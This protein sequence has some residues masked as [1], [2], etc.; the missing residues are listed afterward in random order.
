MIVWR[1]CIIAFCRMAFFIAVLVGLSCT[2]AMAA[3][4]AAGSRAYNQGDYQGALTHWRPL[5]DQGDRRA[6]YNLGV[7]YE[8][9]HGVTQDSAQAT[10]LWKQAATSGLVWAQ[11]NLGLAL[12]SLDSENPE[13]DAGV[14]WL[15]RASDQGFAQS[16]YALAE[17]YAHGQGVERNQARAIRL[18]QTAAQQGLAEAQY[19]L[20]RLYRDGDGVETDLPAAIKWLELAA[21]N[22]SPAAQNSLGRHYADGLGVDQDDIEALKWIALSAQQKYSEALDNKRIMTQRMS[23]EQIR[24]AKKRIELWNQKQNSRTDSP[25]S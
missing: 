14:K 6:Q 21:Q 9:G 20:G 7:M 18:Y 11:H 10:A 5:A 25:T 24:E 23:E 15:I 12:V 3:D 17:I 13:Y 2:S 19:K 4:F 22:G 1:D 8:R 16:Q